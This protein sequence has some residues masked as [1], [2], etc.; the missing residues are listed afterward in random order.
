MQSINPFGAGA[1][2]KSLS[3]A[4]AESNIGDQYY[5]QPTDWKIFAIVAG[6]GVAA[7][8]LLAAILKGGR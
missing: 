2:P 7:L 1:A 8:A 6:A 5:Y 3:S 4:S